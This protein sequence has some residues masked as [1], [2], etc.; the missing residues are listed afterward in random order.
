MVVPLPRWLMNRYCKLWVRFKKNEFNFKDVVK[1]LNDNEDT[2]GV[3]LSNFRKYGWLSV[4]IDYK[5]ARKRKYEL[6]C[7]EDAVSEIALA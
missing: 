6:I 1:I 7:P 2:I 4:N 3:I 5:D